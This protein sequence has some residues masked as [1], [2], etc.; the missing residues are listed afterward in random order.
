MSFIEKKSDKSYI[1]TIYVKPNSRKQKIEQDG[2]FLAISL[3][4]KAQR[5]KANK[6]LIKLLQNK[7]NISSNQISFLSGAYNEDKIIQINFLKEINENKL[8]DML[9]N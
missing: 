2:N 9:L 1:L 5:N 4:S 6:E 3:K 7:L 8:I